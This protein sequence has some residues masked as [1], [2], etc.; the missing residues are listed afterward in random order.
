MNKLIRSILVAGLVASTSLV[1]AYSTSNGAIYDDVGQTVQLRGVNWFGF[2]T[3]NYVVHGLWSRNWKDMIL[4]MKSVGF[5]AVRVPVCPGTLQGSTPTGID[6]AQNPD[7]VNKNSLQIL[8]LVLAELDH[9]GMYIL[10]DHHRPD[11]NSI[12]ELWYTGAYSEQAWINDLVTMANRYKTLPHMVGIDLKNEPHGA[13]TWGTGNVSTDW[14]TAAGKAATAILTAAPNL[15]MFVEGIESNPSCTGSINHWWGGNLEPL[16]CTPLSIPANRLVLAP[17]VYG[18]DVY[19]QPYF[20]DPNFPNNM[21]AIWD[22]HFG[23]FHDAGYPL[24]IGETGGRYGHGG[25][26]KDKIF[27]DALVDYLVNKGISN[28]FYWSW[29]PNSGDT[30]GI[31]QDDWHS[32]WQDKLDLLARLWGNANNVPPAC[33]DGFDNDN[34][35]LA[36]YPAD[37][38]CTSA[39]DHDETDPLPLPAVCADGL[40]ND[41]DGKIDFPNDPGCSSSSDNDEYNAPLPPAGSLTN[42]VSINAD[43]VSGYCANVDVK[44]S[45]SLAVLWQISLPVQ[46]QIYTLWNAIYTQTGS[47]LSAKGVD[48]N[49]SVPAG[50]TVQFGF[51]ANR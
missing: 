35:G 36:D 12:T 47:T 6:F 14:N 10:L 17:H 11:C 33:A 51:C 46:G 2:E 4:Q 44:N 45:G 43:W 29:N 34:D 30:G 8:D 9:Q 19:N 25:S 5:N 18:P 39:T 22:A 41:N 32:V 40:D 26:A 37:L 28:L 7:L 21:P 50:G 23:Q 3:Q 49:K 13:A 31:L 24:A 38:G 27:Q 42:T 15:L 48:W 20:S 16:T 1:H